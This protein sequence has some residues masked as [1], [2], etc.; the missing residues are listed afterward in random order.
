MRRL[1]CSSQ[2]LQCSHAHATHTPVAGGSHRQHHADRGRPGAA[3]RG[4]VLPARASARRAPGVCRCV[5]VLHTGTASD[6][7]NASVPPPPLPTKQPFHGARELIETNEASSVPLSA[8]TASCRVHGLAQWQ[9]L[10]QPRAGDWFARFA[11]K[12]QRQQQW[13]CAGADVVCCALLHAT[14]AHRH[15]LPTCST[16]P[17]CPAPRG[18]GGGAGV[19]AAGG[20]G[21]VPL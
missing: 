19:C 13:G 8:V 20:A 12:V 4:V 7:H 18:A 5:R 6:V 17:P 9:G 3:Q 2:Q 1:R 21:A 15:N 14:S 16:H 10:H 11:Y